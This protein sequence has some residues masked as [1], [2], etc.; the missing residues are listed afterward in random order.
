MKKISVMLIG[1]VLST[2]VL[3]APPITN[4]QGNISSTLTDAQQANIGSL[5]L[6]TYTG[7]MQAAS[8]LAHQFDS[9]TSDRAIDKIHDYCLTITEFN[10]RRGKL[11]NMNHDQIL[12]QHMAETKEGIRQ[13]LVKNNPKAS[14]KEVSG[15][16]M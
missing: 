12:S 15:K 5:L 4:S 14:I 13:W 11:L 9:I 7:C 6:G 16:K 8:Q 1:L 10:Q 3:S 2:S